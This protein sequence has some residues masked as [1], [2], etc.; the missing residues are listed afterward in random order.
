M[1]KKRISRT[2][3][4]ARAFYLFWRGNDVARVAWKLGISVGLAKHYHK[5]HVRAE[6]SNDQARYGKT[7]REE[8]LKMDSRREADALL[9]DIPF[10]A[11]RLEKDRKQAIRDVLVRISEARKN[12]LMDAY[13]APIL[14]LLG[15]ENV[16]DILAFPLELKDEEH[17]SV[18]NCRENFSFLFSAP[19]INDHCQCPPGRHEKP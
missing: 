11:K 13:C 12:A 2:H 1:A 8:Y 3:L 16:V 19:P 15:D 10:Y 7:L 4:Q 6:K 18:A 14:E 17:N 9:A 5:L